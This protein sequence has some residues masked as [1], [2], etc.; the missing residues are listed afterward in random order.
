[1]IQFNIEPQLEQ[2]WKP[3]IV[4]QLHLLLSSALVNVKSADIKFQ[5]QHDKSLNTKY[6]YCQL[7]GRSLQDDTYYASTKNTDGR[8]AIHDVFSKIRRSIIR[9]NKHITLDEKVVPI[10]TK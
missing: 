4:R 7:D 5:M 3:I 1:M 10:L 8:I 9:S 6:Y 2:Q